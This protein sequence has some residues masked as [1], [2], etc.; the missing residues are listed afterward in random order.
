[1][2]LRKH[3]AKPTFGFLV[4]LASNSG[5]EDAFDLFR[6]FQLLLQDLDQLIRRHSVALLLVSVTIA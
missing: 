3:A 5:G 2:R 1:M 6:L 4:R